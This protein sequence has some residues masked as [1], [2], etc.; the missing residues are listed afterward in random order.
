MKSIQIVGPFF[1]NYSYARVNRGL[2]LALDKIQKDYKVSLYCDKESIDYYPTDEELNSKPELKALFNPHRQESDIVIYNNF[3]KSLTAS[4]NLKELPGKVKIMCVAWEESIYP[5]AWVDEINENIDIVMPISDFTGEILRKSGV[6]VPIITAHIALDDHLRE[7]I[8]SPYNISTEKKFKFMHISTAKKRKGIDV[9]LK[10]YLSTFTKND[11]VSLIIKSFPGPDNEVERLLSELRNENS[12][13]VIHINNPDLADQEIAWLH[14]YADC[15]IYPSRAEGFGLPILEAIYFETPV[16][17]TGYSGQTD[18]CNNDNSFL[19]DYKLDYATDSELVNVG[20][21]WAEPSTEHLGKLM[22]E[23]FE[24]INEK[25]TLDKV[26]KA[27]DTADTFTWENTAKK[28]LSIIKDAEAIHE[29]KGQKIA[30]ITPINDEGGI[31]DYSSDLYKSIAKSFREFFFIANSDIADRTEE[32]NDAVKR[33][34]VTGESDFNRTLEFIESMKID[35]VHIQYHSGSFYSPEVLDGLIAN[36]KKLNKKVF[37]TLHAVRNQNFDFIKEVENLKLADNV[38]IHNTD[39]YDYAK[40]TLSN[41]LLYPH[42]NITFAKRETDKIR[43]ELKLSNSP[44]IATHGLL[45]TNKGIPEVINSVH[46]LKEEYPNI[47]LLCLNAVSSNNI[48]AAS[49]YEECQNYIKNN[50]LESNVR[51]FPEFLS[52]DVIEI[53]LQSTD[54][55]IFNYSDVGESASAAVRKGLA[56]L[57]PLIITNIKQFKEFSNECYMI[58]DN[59]PAT[60]S[61]AVKKVLNDSELQKDLLANTAKYIEEKR[62]EKKALDL[63]KLI[64]QG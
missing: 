27:K 34:W 32:D 55:I 62:V 28:A 33:L 43:E 48:M 63:L 16:I 21:K 59:Q 41:V 56:A 44:I 8:P 40:E 50:N 52:D 22:K 38:L 49:L 2:A 47:L 4:N 39:D 12:P 15:E 9:L 11:D 10:A 14:K 37:V 51:F 1:T 25:S 60:I 45:N 18:F 5:K 3:P 7:L 26:K 36:L 30:V 23:V 53:L 46:L 24:N 57:K 54:L 17:T 64:A 61:A 29:I 20:A 31:S 19:I 6:Q 35:I 42:F 13:E 58:Q